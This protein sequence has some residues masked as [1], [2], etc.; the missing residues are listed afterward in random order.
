MHEAEQA[1][2]ESEPDPWAGEPLRHDGPLDWEA[3]KSGGRLH[4]Y[5]YLRDC[6]LSLA[7]LDATA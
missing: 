1:A 6:V 3:F 5:C 7:S 4:L 2:F